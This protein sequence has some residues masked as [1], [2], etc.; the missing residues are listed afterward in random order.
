MMRVRTLCKLRHDNVDLF[1]A[2]IVLS[3]QLSSLFVEVSARFREHARLLPGSKSCQS[4]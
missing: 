2:W 4:H 1:A 3:V